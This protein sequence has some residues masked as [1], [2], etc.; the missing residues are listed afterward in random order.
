MTQC[1]FDHL[2]TMYETEGLDTDMKN[3][4]HHCSNCQNRFS[5]FL[6][7]S[8]AITLAG[9]QESEGFSLDLPQKELPSM[10][11]NMVK[12]RKEKWKRGQLKKVLKFKNIKD[13]SDQ[14]II[15]NRLLKEYPKDLPKAAF[16]D[17]QGHEDEE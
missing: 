16:P 1:N 17:E 11:K 9:D 15:I 14:Q 12:E 8:G 2:I 6:A 13:E 10:L 3:H 4:L 5:K 7:L